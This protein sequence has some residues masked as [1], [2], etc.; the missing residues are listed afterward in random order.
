[1]LCGYLRDERT[2]S[3]CTEELVLEGTDVQH[4]SRVD[5]F[6]GVDD[7]NRFLFASLHD[8]HSVCSCHKQVVRFGHLETVDTADH[9]EVRDLDDNFTGETESIGADLDLL[10]T[11]T[12]CPGWLDSGVEDV[13]PDRLLN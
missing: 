5:T 11:R 1:M 2:L 10:H 12:V 4:Y 9:F 13:R 3:P 6:E 8:N 7:R